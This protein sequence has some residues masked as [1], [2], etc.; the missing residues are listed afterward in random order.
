MKNPLGMLLNQAAIPFVGNSGVGRGVRPLLGSGTP[1]QRSQLDAMGASGTLFAVVNRTSTATA[2]VGWHLHRK[3]PALRDSTCEYD[4]CDAIG[5]SWVEKHPSLSVLE[6]PNDFYTRQELVES[7]QQHLD[8]TGECWLIIERMGSVPFEL[9]VAR[10]D[11][12]QPVANKQDFI[13]GYIY[14]TPDGQEMPL[15]KENV[16]FIRMPNP[17]DPFRGM[18]PV[19][20]IL[21]QIDSARYSAE[22]NRNFFANGS[23]PGGIIKIAKN[24]RDD[25]FD[26]LVERWER[27]HRGIANAGRTAFLEDG[28]WQE[29]AQM[30]MTDMQFVET[31]N[32]NRD[33]ILLA[34]GM[35]KFAVGVVDDVNRAT[36]EA[37]KAWF[38]ETLTVPRLDRWKGMFNNDFLPQFPGFAYD[39]EL[40]Y[41]NPV[42]ADREADRQDKEAAVKN[43]IALTGAGVDPDEA[44]RFCGLPVMRQ[45]QKEVQTA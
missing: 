23:R 13:V 24:M 34:F 44:A 1:D 38:A 21:N 16:M 35:S 6:K 43:Y 36:A 10:P 2:K 31:A 41:T 28:D 25:D 20:T 17:V 18:G 26:Q 19:Q 9:W 39:L 37:S 12:M 14:T 5:V 45:I 27:N 15:R 3:G 7:G 8:L 33:T 29:V 11:R 30:K 40:V 4:G 22:W 42:P 32:L